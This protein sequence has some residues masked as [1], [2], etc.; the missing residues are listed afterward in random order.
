MENSVKECYYKLKECFLPVNLMEGNL[1]ECYYKLKD[2][3][4]N[5]KSINQILWAHKFYRMRHVAV[6]VQLPGRH[7]SCPPGYR[8]P[9]HD[10]PD[11]QAPATQTTAG[12][13]TRK[14]DFHDE[15]SW[16][17]NRPSCCRSSFLFSSGSAA[18]ARPLRLPGA[19]Q[20]LT[21]QSA[22]LPTCVSDQHS[23]MYV[24]K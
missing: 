13:A 7:T 20:R 10:L 12:V 4:L 15:G 14:L 17:L 22:W 16:R 19:C 23:R 11:R 24:Y 2:C 18:T 3:K 5:L 9:Q 6:R 8:V 1:K 21:C